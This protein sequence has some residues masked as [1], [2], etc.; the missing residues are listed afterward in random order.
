VAVT[1]AD[2]T[3]TLVAIILAAAVVS[4]FWRMLGAMAS[5][6]ID[7]SSPAYTLVKCVA[8][9][10]IA[11][12]VAKLVLYP[13]GLLGEVP[14]GLRTGAMAAGFAA[15]LVTRRSMVVGTIV[16]TAVLAMGVAWAD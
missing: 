5:T 6:R 3:W 13:T 12:I 10:L 1:E 9:A 14:I 7:E 4:D 15:Y 16:C 8:T 2:G 11:A